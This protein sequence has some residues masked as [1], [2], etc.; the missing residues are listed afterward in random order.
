ME[1]TKAEPRMTVREHHTFHDR[2]KELRDLVQKEPALLYD[3]KRVASDPFNRNMKYPGSLFSIL[4]QAIMLRIASES[5]R[6][7][8]PWRNTRLSVPL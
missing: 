3:G 6:Y 1:A 5:N 8:T 4:V 2:Q 7:L